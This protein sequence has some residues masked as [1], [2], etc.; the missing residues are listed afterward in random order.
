MGK[1]LAFIRR[2]KKVHAPAELKIS[3]PGLE[4]DIR[5]ILGDHALSDAS[6]RWIL[7]SMLMLMDRQ[8]EQSQLEM[9]RAESRLQA[10]V[11]AAEEEIAAAKRRKKGHL[12]AIAQ[13]VRKLTGSGSPEAGGGR[14]KG[15]A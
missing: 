10:V 9:E 2:E 13:V 14:T 8:I 11:K 12:R 3:V 1:V 5:E 4:A 15:T 6:R 7:E